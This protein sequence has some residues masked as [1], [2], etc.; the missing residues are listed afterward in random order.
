L[1]AE[2]R[3]LKHAL[4]ENEYREGR[5]QR[6]TSRGKMPFA[7]YDQQFYSCKDLRG[8]EGRGGWVEGDGREGELTEG[9]KS[10]LADSRD[11]SVSKSSISGMLRNRRAE[12]KESR[13]TQ[14]KGR[15]SG[16]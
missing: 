9:D 3:Q 6:V 13:V 11:E 1:L 14:I 5:V 16:Q 12:F 8:A 4:I 10:M 15:N 2:N 7:L